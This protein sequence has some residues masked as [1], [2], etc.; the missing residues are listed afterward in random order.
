MNGTDG[1]NSGKAPVWAA[2]CVKLLQGP[3]YRTNNADP[4][5]AT[6]QAWQSEI[7]RYFWTIGLHVYVDAA[8]GYAFLEQREMG[9][10]EEPLPKLIQER[11]L[12]MQDSLLCVLFREALD[13]FDSS[14]DQSENLILSTSEIKE[15]LDSFF[16]E[17][18][19][20]LKAMR[21][22]DES[23]NKLCGLSFIREMESS[24]SFDRT[25]EIRRILKA[26]INAEFITEF[27]N[28]LKGILGKED[29]DGQ[30][31]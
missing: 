12:T 25:F 19:D 9:E 1:Q 28:K 11:Q 29:S 21:R 30:D 23:L 26:K 17:K 4:T 16:P 31:L 22:L 27:R 14:Q 5:W 3:V 2:V 24:G 15:R 18:K 6:L 20:Q 8:D 7:D 13:Q 10:E